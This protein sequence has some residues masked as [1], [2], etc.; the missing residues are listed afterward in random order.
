M[1][2][3]A[4]DALAKP[5][6]AVSNKEVAKGAGLSALS[7]LGALIE[8]VAQPAY[9]WMFG[10]TGYGVYVVLWAAINILANILDLAM[11]QALQRVIPAESS[12]ERQHG[13]VKFAL[14]TGTGLGIIAAAVMSLSASQLASYVAAAP[15][16]VAHIPDAIAL[17]AWSLPL[18][19]FVEIATAAARAKRAFGPEIRLRIFWEQLARLLFAA[20]FFAAGYNLTGLLLGHMLS[21]ALT[22]ILSVRL[23]GRYYDLRLLVHA[24]MPGLL[25]RSVLNSGAAMLPPALARRAYNDLPPILLNLMVPGAGGAT[26]AAFYGIARKIASLPLIVRQSF[27]YVL[28]PLASA[29]ASVDRNAMLPMY[30]FSTHISLLLAVPLAGLLIL[31]A[32]DILSAFAPGSSAALP[33]LIILLAARAGEAVIGPATPMLKWSATGRCLWSTVSSGYRSG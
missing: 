19:I 2:G 3:P 14:L 8:V 30:R 13:A 20:G 29:Q 9:T 27:L 24:P 15:D 33:V 31:V 21:L 18:W 22:A 6:P 11:G 12:D 16:E 4:E 23:L 25:R 17:F 28:S 10:I 5:A 1:S 32:S 26:A 7:R